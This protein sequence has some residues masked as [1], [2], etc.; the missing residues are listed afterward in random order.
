MHVLRFQDFLIYEN[1]KHMKQKAH[2]SKINF[3]ARVQLKRNCLKA[4]KLSSLP[5]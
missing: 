1:I 3:C 2:V 5:Y 4:Q